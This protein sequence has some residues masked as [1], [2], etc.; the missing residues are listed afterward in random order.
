MGKIPL[1]NIVQLFMCRCRGGCLVIVLVVVLVA[2]SVA[3]SMQ[4]FVI[5]MVHQ[6]STNPY[7]VSNVNST[8]QRTPGCEFIISAG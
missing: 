4:V 2:V 1:S 8:V 5:V 6:L 7:F 3:V